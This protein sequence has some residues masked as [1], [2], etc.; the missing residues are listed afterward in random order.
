LKIEIADII[1]RVQRGERLETI[2]VALLDE[3]QRLALR[4]CASV[5]A[6]DRKLFE[7]V[8]APFLKRASQQVTFEE[9]IEGPLVEAGPGGESFFQVS[10]HV[11]DSLFKTWWQELPPGDENETWGVPEALRELSKSLVQ[12]YEEAVPPRPLDVL[13]HQIAAN[14]AAVPNFFRNLYNRADAQFDLATCENLIRVLERRRPVLS[15]ELRKLKNQYRAYLDARDHWS[16]E[17][18]QT[19]RYYQRGSLEENFLQFLKHPTQWIFH[20]HAPGGRGKTMLLRWAVARKCVPEPAKIPCAWIDFDHVDRKMSRSTPI[21]ILEL[22]IKLLQQLNVQLTGAPLSHL[23]RRTGESLQRV[24]AEAQEAAGKRAIV[25]TRRDIADFLN[26]QMPEVTVLLIFDTLEEAWLHHLLDLD[27]LLAELTDLHRETTGIRVVLSGRYRLFDTGQPLAARKTEDVFDVSVEKFYYEEAWNYLVEQRKLGRERPLDVAIERA[28]GNPFKLA[29]LADILTTNAKMT[30]E[31]L[32]AY[33][34]VDFAYLVERVISRIQDKQVRWVLRYGVVP[35]KLTLLFLREVMAP[36]LAQVMSGQLIFDNPKL[37]AEEL[38]HEGLFLT[39]LLSSPDAVLKLPALWEALSRFASRYSWVSLT[40]DDSATLRF[41]PDV[42][43][44][45]RAILRKHE[46]FEL[47]HADAVSYFEGLAKQD[48]ARRNEWLGEVVYHQFQL[49]GASAKG[50]WRRLISQAEEDPHLRRD[51]AQEVLGSE[52]LDEHRKARTRPGKDSQTE[53]IIDDETIAD[54]WFE[55]ARAHVDLARGAGASDAEMALAVAQSA[56]TQF[57]KLQSAASA[58]V[59]QARLA[60][61]EAAI[62]ASSEGAEV[63]QAILLQ[64]L[65]QA[66]TPSER[67][68]LLAALATSQERREPEKALEQYR[69]ATMIAETAKVPKSAHSDVLRRHGELLFKL[70]RFEEA[71]R[72]VDNAIHMGWESADWWTR[73]HL[74][75]LLGEILLRS[76]SPRS[77]N[78]LLNDVAGIIRNTPD[79]YPT[80]PGEHLQTLARFVR[81]QVQ[82]H[83]EQ[84]NPLGALIALRGFG[85]QIPSWI[86]SEGEG[87]VLSAIGAGESAIALLDSA[88]DVWRRFEMPDAMNQALLQSLPV[89]MWTVRDLQQLASQLEQVDERSLTDEEQRFEYR[90]FRVRLAAARQEPQKSV[91]KLLKQCEASGPVSRARVALEALAVGHQSEENYLRAAKALEEVNPPSARLR[92]ADALERCG[93]SP[94]SSLSAAQRLDDALEYLYGNSFEFSFILAKVDSLRIAARG[95]QA[96]ALLDSIEQFL[97]FNPDPFNRYFAWR[98]VLRARDRLG[99]S[100]HLPT[101]YTDTVI[102]LFNWCLQELASGFRLTSEHTRPREGA[103]IAQEAATGLAASVAAEHLDRLLNIEGEDRAAEFLSRITKDLYA[104]EKDI[105]NLTRAIWGA[106]T[107]KLAAFRQTF[108]EAHKGRTPFSE[109]LTATLEVKQGLEIIIRTDREASATIDAESSQIANGI[110]STWD[111]SSAPADLTKYLFY[112]WKRG[113][114]EIREMLSVLDES[115]GPYRRGIE[116][117]PPRQVRLVT[118]DL[119]CAAIPWELALT[120]DEPAQFAFSRSPFLYRLGPT[121]EAE[122]AEPAIDESLVRVFSNALSSHGGPWLWFTNFPEKS[123][124]A[125]IRVLVVTALNSP[126]GN[127]EQDADA[128]SF[129]VE[130]FYREAGC[131]VDSI[132]RPSLLSLSNV[133]L[134]QEFDVV[135]LC[136][137]IGESSQLGG[138]YLDFYGNQTYQKAFQSETPDSI[139]PE[140]LARTFAAGK[141]G[142][143]PP[144]VIL[145]V[146]AAADPYECMVQLFLRNTFAAKLAQTQ[147]CRA[148]IA[149]GFRFAVAGN[150]LLQTIARTIAERQT[151]EVLMDKLKGEPV[152]VDSHFGQAPSNPHEVATIFGRLGT[153][154]FCGDPS[155]PLI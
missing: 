73:I 61:V 129:P 153:A 134:S 117:V 47:L 114:R 19:T 48:E 88:R 62:A 109:T 32:R 43:N 141:T 80:K 57:Q 127:W 18:F 16:R 106:A 6:F 131:W 74:T 122:R 1:E 41:H 11:V 7:K 115:S 65:K 63:A 67:F 151:A 116:L 49:A 121:T 14:P 54:A 142:H 139:T 124:D 5:T 2:Q 36:Y 58:R 3:R 125:P 102:Q 27:A 40:H 24:R 138:T 97:K 79:L 113:C 144:L 150:Q 45:M 92:L 126:N 93:Q 52:Y 140:A 84:W 111:D 104:D 103:G 26:H 146:M 15:E 152:H 60:L 130:H 33:P 31:D 68:A 94:E 20:V 96:R 46:V 39:D 87:I 8:F 51:L 107:R 145:D 23:I 112:D 133:N 154:L 55:L 34:R 91:S 120:A 53:A 9:V 105:E 132:E 12:Y 69:E 30:G 81:L 42:I 78:Y 10:S 118:S 99:W 95:E 59:T 75:M 85:K 101:V 119:R 136:A 89:L 148:I 100:Q 135:H 108:T 155:E 64:A 149:T 29:L 137:A 110:L 44:P 98:D 70:E 35:R 72:I 90:L 123:N 128:S 37:D 13:Y 50:Y 28:E 22:Y 76:G 17:Y 143:R 86:L 56:F 38:Q 21:W 82:S 4:L 83:L 77:A 66:P 147:G 71:Y 25:R